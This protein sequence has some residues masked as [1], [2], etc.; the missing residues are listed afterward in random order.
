M[1]RHI[2]RA[3]ISARE[4]IRYSL[5]KRTATAGD[6]SK[7]SHTSNIVKK[8]LAHEIPVLTPKYLLQ[9]QWFLFLA[10]TYS[11]PLQI[12][13]LFTIHK[14]RRGAAQPQLRSVAEIA[15]KSL[16]LCVN[17]SPIRYGF[18]ACAKAISG[19]G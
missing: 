5:N 9:T 16:F 7:R 14:D 6:W 15:S 10:P 18:R 11:L 1:F 3:D 13:Y 2:F 8:R 17:R 12:K 4:P 19:I